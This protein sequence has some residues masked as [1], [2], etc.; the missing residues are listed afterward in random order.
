[1]PYILPQ[2]VRPDTAPYIV[3]KDLFSKEECQKIVDGHKE[4]EAEKARIGGDEIDG[5]IN[6]SKRS[7]DIRWIDWNKDSDWIFE[8]LGTSVVSANN[9]WWGYALAGMNEPLQLTHYKSE[10]KGHYDWHEDHGHTGNFLHRKLSCILPLNNEFEGGDFEFFHIGKPAEIS[11]GTLIIFPSFK[12]H[13]V[14][15]VTSGERWSLVSWVNGPP[16]C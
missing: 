11:V 16:F 3:F 4:K 13:R 7:T 15:P 6:L 10:D 14:L 8:K 12:L 2:P 9:R 5:K 1:M